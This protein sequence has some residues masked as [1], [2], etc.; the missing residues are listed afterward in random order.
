MPPLLYKH[1]SRTM[2]E[3]NEEMEKVSSQVETIEDLEQVSLLRGFCSW[4]CGLTDVTVSEVLA[5]QKGGIEALK[6]GVPFE[7]VNDF[8]LGKLSKLFKDDWDKTK[9]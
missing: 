4:L 8:F 5:I 2:S 3:I 1:I 6:K 9:P 7:D